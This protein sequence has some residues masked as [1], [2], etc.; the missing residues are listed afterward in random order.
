MFTGAGV[1]GNTKVVIQQKD[2]IIRMAEYVNNLGENKTR[3]AHDYEWIKQNRSLDKRT[4]AWDTAE[5]V[6]ETRN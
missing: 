6:G 4:H 2:Y 1:S 5:G 3:W